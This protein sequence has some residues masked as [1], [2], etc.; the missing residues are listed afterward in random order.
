MTAQPSHP[1]PSEPV[2]VTPEPVA[3]P[4]P[5]ASS[6]LTVVVPTYNEA[7]NLPVL[8][9][10][11]MALPLPGLHLVVVDDNSP[12]GTGEIADKLALEHPGR[13]TVVHR[14]R[15]DGLG[16]AY[17]AGM[18]RALEDG[19]GFVAQMD[20]DLSH[21]AGYL[22]Q[23]LGTLHSTN[24]GVVIGS[25]YV[26]GGSL[27]E[28]WGMRRRLLSGWANTYVKTVLSIPVR[29]VTAGFKLWRASALHALD[30]PSIESTG[31]AFQVEMHY[32]AY[33]RG[34]KIVEIPIHFEDRVEGSSKLDGAV[35]L[36]AALRPLRLRRSERRR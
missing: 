23:L 19:A 33:R 22:P 28:H 15:K 21:P 30:L 1:D 7:A 12:D 16:R 8:T 5:W 6:P 9:A 31:Y 4:E 17:V 2:R 29:D 34:Q 3:L 24:A 36:E 10:Q 13:I 18:T 11:L 27:S 32:R 20:A 14:T 25:R 26:P 35:A